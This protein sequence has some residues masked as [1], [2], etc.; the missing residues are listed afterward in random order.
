MVTENTHSQSVVS[1]PRTNLSVFISSSHRKEECLVDEYVWE[2][3]TGQGVRTSQ[4][5]NFYKNLKHQGL[6]EG[7]AFQIGAGQQQVRSHHQ[8]QSLLLFNGWGVVTM[9]LLPCIHQGVWQG[10]KKHCGVAYRRIVRSSEA[11]PHPISS[12]IISHNLV[13]PLSS[14][15]R[16]QWLNRQKQVQNNF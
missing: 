7:R 9:I 4:P 13:K 3:W 2:H 15:L 1:L 12:H 11:Q 16:S 14:R 6:S 10:K 8:P 5:S